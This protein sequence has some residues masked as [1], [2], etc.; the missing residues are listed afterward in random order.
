MTDVE[1]SYLVVLNGEEQYSIWRAG[2]PVPA[3]W[4]AVGEPAP[5]QACLAR[6]GELWTDM[7]PASLRAAMDGPSE[8]AA[9]P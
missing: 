2:R 8:S 9:H 6:I 1:D 3:G 5:R 7:R 4:S